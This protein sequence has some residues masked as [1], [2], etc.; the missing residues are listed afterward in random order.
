M[1][2]E[3]KLVECGNGI[4]IPFEWIDTTPGGSNIGHAEFQV[5]IKFKQGKVSEFWVYPRQ[6]RNV[7]TYWHYVGGNID[8]TISSYERLEDAKVWMIHYCKEHE[9]TSFNLYVP[10]DSKYLRIDYH[11]LNFQ[12][13]KW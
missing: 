4:T 9:A 2:K 6:Q 12:R 10:K 8:F 5:C 1:E 13:T 7:D 3:W 11:G